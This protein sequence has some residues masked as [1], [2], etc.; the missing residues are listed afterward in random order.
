MLS[1]LVDWVENGRAPE[2]LTVV[3]QQPALPIA[4]NRALPLCQWPSWPHYREGMP[5]AQSVSSARREWPGAAVGVAGL[6]WSSGCDVGVLRTHRKVV[7]K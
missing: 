4:V 3:E 1:V 6:G 5:R 7:A 2:D